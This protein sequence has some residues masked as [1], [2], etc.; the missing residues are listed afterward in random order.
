MLLLQERFISTVNADLANNLGNLLNRSMNLIR[1]NCDLMY[2]LDSSE[3]DHPFRETASQ[4]ATLVPKNLE[5]LHF[6]GACQPIVEYLGQ[7]N[8][9]IAEEEPWTLFKQGERERA[10]RCLCTCLEVVRVA[11]VLLKPVTPMLSDRIYR[12]LGL[13]EQQWQGKTAM[14]VGKD[15]IRRSPNKSFKRVAPWLCSIQI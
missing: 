9:Y 1:K 15:D 5:Q 2:E 7:A 10:V 11:G 3:I 13:T 8:L 6:T 14:T 12:S 4:L